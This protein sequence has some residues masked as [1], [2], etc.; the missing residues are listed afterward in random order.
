[1]RLLMNFYIT[2]MFPSMIGRGGQRAERKMI[3]LWQP[4]EEQVRRKRWQNRTSSV[5][6]SPLDWTADSYR[7]LQSPVCCLPGKHDK[8]R[9]SCLWD[10][11]HFPW[12]NSV[13]GNV[14]SEQS[15][16]CGHT[17]HPIRAG[18]EVDG[19]KEFKGLFDCMNHSFWQE[20]TL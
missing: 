10:I 19:K 2:C 8:L 14:V 12:F 20:T 4:A 6:V 7:L 11:F 3:H 15:G 16:T 13:K 5:N 1:M 9:H 17:V 18:D